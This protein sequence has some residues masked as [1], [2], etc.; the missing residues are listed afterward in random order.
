MEKG[1]LRRLVAGADLLDEPLP[2][3]PL[4]EIAGDCRVLIEHHCGVTQYGRCRI[5][6]RVKYGFV[7]VIGRQLELAQMT[8]EQLIITGKIDTVQ[9][10]RSDR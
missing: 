1:M 9:L 8:K 5:C 3:V 4:I 7:V 10:E 2:G 6:V